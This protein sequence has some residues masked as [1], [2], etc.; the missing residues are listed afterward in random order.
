M[1]QA[2][3]IVIVIA[4]LC[5]I[6]WAVVFICREMGYMTTQVGDYA[7]ISLAIGVPLLDIVAL[8]VSLM[9]GDKE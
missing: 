3:K 6:A 9:L 7:Y 4:L 5:T 1:R 8:T 2:S